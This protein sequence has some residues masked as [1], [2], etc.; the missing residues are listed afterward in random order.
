MSRSQTE[1]EQEA[2]PSA[3]TALAKEGHCPDGVWETLSTKAG[4]EGGLEMRL[5]GNRV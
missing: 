1:R 3:R 2:N 4:L 5:V